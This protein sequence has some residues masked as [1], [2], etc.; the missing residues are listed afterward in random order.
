PTSTPA[1]SDEASTTQAPAS[2]V[3]SSAPATN[4]ATGRV[5]TLEG[6]VP[7]YV[8]PPIVDGMVPVL[9]KV[10]TEQKV[11]FLTIDDGAIKRDSDFALLEKNGVKASLFL[12]HNFIAGSADF[13]K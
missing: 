5:D 11:V 8:L 10:P 13:Y 12:A 4:P 2:D 1:A 3:P 6:L 7:D 9:T